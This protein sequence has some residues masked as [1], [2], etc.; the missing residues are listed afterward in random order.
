MRTD[1]GRGRHGWLAAALLAAAAA[2]THGAWAAEEAGRGAGGRRQ[3]RRR[4]AELARRQRRIGHTLGAA[5][6][7][8]FRQLL[9]RVPFAQVRALVAPGAG[10]TRPAA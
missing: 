1:R 10:L 7:A 9:P 6:R 3:V 4:L 2:V 8:Q 5:R